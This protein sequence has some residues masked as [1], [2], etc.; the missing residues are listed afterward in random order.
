MIG[1]LIALGMV[2]CMIAVILWAIIVFVFKKKDPLGFAIWDEENEEWY[3][4]WFEK[5]FGTGPE[6]DCKFTNSMVE[7]DKNMPSKDR[8]QG[9]FCNPCLT[10]PDQ[11]CKDKNEAGETLYCRDALDKQYKCRTEDEA[12]TACET[13]MLFDG[14]TFGRWNTLKKECELL[15]SINPAEKSEDS[16]F[17][18]SAQKNNHRDDKDSKKPGD[19]VGHVVRQKSD[20]RL[21]H[22]NRYNPRRWYP[23]ANQGS[24]H[25]ICQHESNDGD[26]WF[27]RG[28]DIATNIDLDGYVKDEKLDDLPDEAFFKFIP[29]KGIHPIIHA[30]NLPH[31]RAFMDDNDNMH[32]GWVKIKNKKNDKYI[33][34]KTDLCTHNTNSCNKQKLRMC[35]NKNDALHF[36]IYSDQQWNTWKAENEAILGDI[37]CSEYDSDPDEYFECRHP[38]PE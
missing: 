14:M 31:Y 25:T 33:C 23:Q 6:N 16:L 20:N 37:D 22:H 26:C 30:T 19:V 12:R 36:R 4:P 32:R 11:P 2:L 17:F 5:W 27:N 24:Y 21:Y 28:F 18:Y 1:K 3:F 34:G 10:T 7:Y 13:N 9:E 35:S 29:T 8:N 38:D 15:D